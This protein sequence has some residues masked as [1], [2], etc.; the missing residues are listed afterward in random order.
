MLGN[1]ERTDAKISDDYE[2]FLK[3]FKDS[4]ESY[5]YRN[6][7]AALPGLGLK[8]LIVDFQDLVAFSSDQAVEF[9]KEPKR[10]LSAFDQAMCRVLDIYDPEY[11]T[12]H[13]KDLHVRVRE[14]Y[15]IL[16]LRAVPD[17]VKKFVMVGGLV[18]RASPP[19]PSM[20]TAVYKC[21]NGHKSIVESSLRKPIQCDT[22]DCDAKVFFLDKDASE[23]GKYQVVKIQEVPEELPGGRIPESFDVRLE[24]DLI[25]KARPGDRVKVT[26]IVDVEIAGGRFYDQKYMHYQLL[27]NHVEAIGK[28]PDDIQI[29]NE[30]TEQIKT[31][32]AHPAAYDRLIESVA[33]NVE[34]E[35]LAKESALLVLA[36]SYPVLLK[37]GTRLRGNIHGFMCGDPGVAKSDILL[38]CS[39]AAPR[40]VFANG[41][42][43]SAAGLT[44]SIVREK[45]GLMMLEPGATVLADQ[46]ICAIDEFS[47]MREEDRVTLHEVME[48][49]TASINKAGFI[50]TLNART[51]IIA[52]ANPPTGKYD[53]YKTLLEN[54]EPIPI[55]LLTRFDLIVIMR[56]EIEKTRDERVARKILSLTSKGDYSVAPP[57]D[58]DLFKKFIS[59]VRTLKPELG[60]DVYEIIIKKYQEIR[61][62]F[63]S[64]EGVP[65]TPRWLES[66][67]RISIARAR[68][69]LHQRVTTDDV[70]RASTLLDLTLKSAMLDP[71]TKKQDPG[72]LMGTPVRGIAKQA[73]ALKVFKEL[74]GEE[75]K[76]VRDT[77]FVSALIKTGEFNEDTSWKMFHEMTRSVLYE[78]GRGEYKKA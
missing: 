52:A 34:G 36:G 21:P 2:I 57:M 61:Q 24:E 74:S 12:T 76:A 15:D 65:I 18:T 29:S 23:F 48:Q 25:G 46:G 26:G 67:I 3:T 20:V 50:A 71:Q 41:R 22:E 62:S 56:D 14:L 54:L 60:E 73:L 44:A 55:P 33:P 37:D 69:L 10:N 19:M 63:A 30:E 28:S 7:V 49:G 47:H 8:S 9:A 58:F 31:F 51:S 11:R 13:E 70:L 39:R 42:N 27:C 17:Y 16:P 38:F 78:V 64:T 59:Y 66:L 35:L 32:V 68:L 77:E 72:I 43:S 45:N 53:V 40:A 6:A 4:S 5:K 1:Q 75:K